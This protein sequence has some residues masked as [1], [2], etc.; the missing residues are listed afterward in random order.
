MQSFRLWQRLKLRWAMRGTPNH[1]LTTGSLP[2]TEQHA[3]ETSAQKFKRERGFSEATDPLPWSEDISQ[4]NKAVAEEYNAE[5]ALRKLAYA[6]G[7]Y[8]PRM[9]CEVWHPEMGEYV[10][11]VNWDLEMTLMP[12]RRVDVTKSPGVPMQPAL[13]VSELTEARIAG[14]LAREV[15][16][17][18][19]GTKQDPK[20]PRE[21]IGSRQ[22]ILANVGGDEAIADQVEESARK[23]FGVEDLDAP[24]AGGC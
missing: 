4:H 17:L 16:A 21:F 7:R 9:F 10:P 24:L 6:E 3:E 11:E 22:T 13:T 19:Q 1:P 5:I 8:Q 20:T 15:T 18:E 23:A 14:N 2:G 12:G